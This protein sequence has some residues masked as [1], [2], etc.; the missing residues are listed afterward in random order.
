M[1]VCSDIVSRLA[2]KSLYFL[3][4]TPGGHVDAG[5]T[6][7]HF[8]KS[9]PVEIVMHNIGSIDSIGNV[10]F[11]A[12]AKRYATE[13]STFL[14]HGVASNFNKDIALPLNQMDEIRSKLAK[15]QEKIAGIIKESTKITL[16]EIR[17]LFLYGESKDVHFALKKGIIH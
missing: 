17:K 9:L 1:A 7:H 2:P 16:R 3:L 10:V 6:L 11:L 5:I 14:F 8:L 15:D 4:S 13:H 12:G